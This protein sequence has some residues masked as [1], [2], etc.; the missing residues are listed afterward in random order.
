MR[1]RPAGL[2]VVL[3]SLFAFG[4]T[5]AEIEFAGVLDIGLNVVR[6]DSANL[7]PPDTAYLTTGWGSHPPY[8]TFIFT[9]VP[10]WPETLKMHGT[11][12]GIP[13]QLTF[14]YPDTSTWY[15]FGS[16]YGPKVKF[17]GTGY[18]A[19]DES[20]PMATPLLRLA[21]S[22]S[23]VTGQM[24]VRLQRVGNSGPVVEIHDATGNVVRS[25]D[26]AAGPD[27]TA[28][29][30]WNREDDRGRLVPEGVYFCRYAAADIVAVRKVLV[31]H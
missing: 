2:A 14:F 4:L 26:C 29:A 24:T 22:P 5:R 12:Q 16:L 6:V 13:F 30:M 7:T 9:G 23:V 15:H 27:G 10:T 1:K 8:D 17:F 3:V 20:K 19:V 11:T 31:A 18:G 21:V 25:L 28:T